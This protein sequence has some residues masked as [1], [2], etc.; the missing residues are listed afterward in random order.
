MWSESIQDGMEKKSSGRWYSEIASFGRQRR[1]VD[2]APR[3]ALSSLPSISIL[4]KSTCGA[5]L[6]MTALSM[7]VVGIADGT[8]RARSVER[9]GGEVWY[10]W[11][12]ELL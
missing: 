7:V 8:M 11:C 1:I 9:R 10:V 2:S 4:M 3:N 12:V 5:L 6:C